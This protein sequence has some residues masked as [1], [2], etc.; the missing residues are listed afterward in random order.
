MEKL[1]SV[2][3]FCPITNIGT[4]NSEY[5]L[6]RARNNLD[7]GT[8]DA[9]AGLLPAGKTMERK[10]SRQKATLARLFL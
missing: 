2:I 3:L 5:F 7:I 9:A 10:E 4:I 6:R 8:L 1:Q